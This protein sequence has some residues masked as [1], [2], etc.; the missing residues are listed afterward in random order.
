MPPQLV[1]LLALK[2]TLISKI[3]KLIGTKS[4]AEIFINFPVK[5]DNPQMSSTNFATGSKYFAATNPAITA[6]ISPTG[7][8]CSPNLKK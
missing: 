3:F 5:K 7:S 1:F 2:K 8:G 4:I 6:F